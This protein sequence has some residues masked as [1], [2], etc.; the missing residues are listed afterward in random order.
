M[1]LLH[2]TINPID[3]LLRKPGAVECWEKIKHFEDW[4]KDQDERVRNFS[5]EGHMHHLYDYVFGKL[6]VNPLYELPNK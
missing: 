5:K 6:D 1:K 4:R 2:K 3:K